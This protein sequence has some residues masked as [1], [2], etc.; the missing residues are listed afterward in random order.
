MW[1]TVIPIPAIQFRFRTA[2]K[3]LH[4]SGQERR[5]A[6]CNCVPSLCRRGNPVPIRWRKPHQNGDQWV[7]CEF[8]FLRKE[9]SHCLLLSGCMGF[10]LQLRFVRSGCGEKLR[11][12]FFSSL[13]RGLPAPAAQEATIA[14]YQLL[15][16]GVIERGRGGERVA[17]ASFAIR[18]PSLHGPRVQ[19]IDDRKLRVLL[20]YASNAS[21]SDGPFVGRNVTSGHGFW[22]IPAVLRQKARCPQPKAERP[23]PREGPMRLVGTVLEPGCGPGHEQ[24][25]VSSLAIGRL[26][27]PCR[28][29]NAARLQS[30]V[31]AH[32]D[33][34]SLAA[35]CQRP[36][37]LRSLDRA[38]TPDAQRARTGS[39]DGWHRSPARARTTA[40]LDGPAA[41][42]HD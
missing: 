11:V 4:L 24:A 15:L 20:S 36:V 23:D 19:T 25:W 30:P 41:A 42:P 29:L 7:N 31:P 1:E 27:H 18:R 26:Q 2:Q 13:P 28:R 32:I 22:Q 21:R 9:R 33:L 17:N 8:R 12:L 16:R 10:G 3:R 37:R 38:R 34:G 5:L 35:R 14:S 40:Q 6:Q 39:I